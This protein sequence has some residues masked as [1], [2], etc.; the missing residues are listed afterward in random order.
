MSFVLLTVLMASCASSRRGEVSEIRITRGAGGVGFLPLMAM[1]KYRLVEKHAA[2]AGVKGLRVHWIDIGG[3][4]VVNDALLSGSADFIAAGPP[5]FLTL[6]DKTLTSTKVNGVAAIS[7]IP[8]YLNTR[9]EHMKQLSDIRVDDR[10]AVTAIKVSIPAIIL[11]M[12]AA[13]RYGVSEAPHFDPFTIAMTHPDGVLA[14]LSGANAIDAHFTSP[15]FHQRELKDPSVRTVLNSD[16]VLGGPATFTMLSTSTAFR[17]H[18]PKVYA[19]VFAALQEAIQMMNTDK[20][21]AAK[22]LFDAMNGGGFTVREMQQ[23]L[24]DPAIRFTTTPE[25]M[26]KYASFM[27][28]IG[29]IKNVP[30]S[31]KDLFFPEVQSAPGS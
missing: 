5:A 15:P 19:T 31:W 24:M 10:I 13:D 6:W 23:I 16:E 28:D 14:L 18:N 20:Y 9:A 11:Q 27:H 7:S 2:M 29:S 8:M 1:E 12:Y 30:A 17:D 4:A 26:M 25:N 3:P 22:L 21:Q